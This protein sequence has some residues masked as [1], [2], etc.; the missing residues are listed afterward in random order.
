MGVTDLII[1]LAAVCELSQ[2]SAAREQ[3]ACW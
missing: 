1:R 3:D 2:V